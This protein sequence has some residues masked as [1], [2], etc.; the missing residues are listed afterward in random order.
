MSGGCLADLRL[1]RLEDS[2]GVVLK[3][4]DNLLCE[5]FMLD[6]LSR[7][8]S[9]PV[10]EVFHATDDCIVMEYLPGRAN[11]LDA[12]AELHLADLVS[13]LHNISSD[14][15][16]FA[17]DTVIGPLRQPGQAADNW[18]AFFRDQRLVY[19]AD[20]ARGAGRLPE[21]V[22]GRLIRLAERL[23]EY[24]GHRPAVSLLHG[25]LWGGNILSAAGRVTG[26]IDPAIYYGDAE[27]ELAFM[28][29]FGTV[30]RDFFDRYG[31]RRPLDSEFFR[32][33][34][35]IYLLYPLLVHVRLFGGSYVRQLDAILGKY[36]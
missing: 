31:E 21:S 1:I 14:H 26:I 36:L 35:D 28:T 34:K 7:H 10:P 33:R 20:Q 11:A 6:Y 2:R 22:Y 18:C 3:Q 4:G 15:F 27:V 24:L 29:L 9:L 25:D 5:A 30:G 16:G 17:R 32:T 19:M 8:S 12:G 23:E 13:E